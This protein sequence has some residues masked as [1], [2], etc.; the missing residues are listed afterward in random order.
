MYSITQNMEKNLPEECC[1]NFS[2]QPYHNR[3]LIGD[4]V[5]HSPE[6]FPCAAVI[7][8]NAEMYTNPCTSTYVSLFISA[9]LISLQK[10]AHGRCTLPLGS[11]W[12]VGW[13]SSY[14]YCVLLSSQSGANTVFY[15]KAL[16]DMATIF[17]EISQKT[18][19]WYS[20]KA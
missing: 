16:F 2:T 15:F 4:L 3:I 18:K 9:C 1:G 10:R 8:L 5:E 19:L 11:N 17:K 14:H 20:F 6:P 13:H 12:G 7:Y